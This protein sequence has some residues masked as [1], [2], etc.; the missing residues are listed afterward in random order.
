MVIKLLN[1]SYP[2]SDYVTIK[3]LSP[4]RFWQWL[5]DSLFK[6]AVLRILNVYYPKNLINFPKNSSFYPNSKY[7]D[8]QLIFLS[9]NSVGVSQIFS[10]RSQKVFCTWKFPSRLPEGSVYQRIQCTMNMMKTFQ[11]FFTKLPLSREKLKQFPCIQLENVVSFV[12]HKEKPWDVGKF[13][14]VP[15]NVKCMECWIVLG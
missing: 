6:S 11:Y 2:T 3:I 10:S 15:W 14:N 7:K 12:R 4:V 5:T 9:V 13:M 8:L 1:I